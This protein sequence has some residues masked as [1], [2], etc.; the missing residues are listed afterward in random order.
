MKDLQAKPQAHVDHGGP[1]IGLGRLFRMNLCLS[2]R[3]H[4]FPTSTG[5]DSHQVITALTV[6]LRVT[7]VTITQACDLIR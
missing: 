4:C 1:R 2:K 3:R 5:R 7:L 6:C